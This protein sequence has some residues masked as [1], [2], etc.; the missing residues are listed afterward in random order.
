MTMK[1][2]DIALK[3]LVRSFRSLF[4]IGMM[5]VVPMVITGLLYFAF[6]G[7]GA[8]TGR[9][10]LPPLRLAL[11][12]LDQAVAGQPAFGQMLVDY[13]ADP[14]MPDWLAVQPA[15]GEA[16]A[17]AAVAARS[18]D[19]ALIIPPDFSATLLAG[20]QPAPLTLVQDPTLTIG[21]QIVQDLVRLYLDSVVGARI[22]VG[23][24]NDQLATRGL[25]LDQA[26]LLAVGQQYGAWVTEAERNI[27]HSTT[28]ILAVVAPAAADAANAPAANDTARMLGSVM[29]GMLIFFV[30]FTGA[31]TAQS[32]LRE[33]EEGTLA[34]L[35][36]TPTPRTTILAGKFLS[37]FVTIVVQ[38]VVLMAAS[39]V[40]FRINWGQPASLALVTLAL[41]VAAAGFGLCL[42]SFLKN[43]RQAGVVI[44]AVLSVGGMLGGLFT[45]GVEMPPAF[46]MFNL[47]LP[48]GWAIRGLKLVLDGGGMAVV[49]VPALVL[50]AIGAGL[51]SVGAVVFRRRFA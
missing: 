42:V 19:V 29:A 6:G 25:T 2:V 37:V 5:F 8:G 50:A 9:F 16:E 39:A 46:Q 23:V 12:N 33:D 51:F 28:P 31:Y 48:Q 4:A 34:R 18:A 32:I 35:F 47:A 21:P 27:H 15:A 30:F 38:A 11:A 13:F 44:G 36:T 40:A 49:L 3:D 1:A 17:R 26:G 24:V 45:T 22:A 10:N 7:L 43:S 14:A 41:T 20:G